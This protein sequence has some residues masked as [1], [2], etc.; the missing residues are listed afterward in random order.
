MSN[1]T[2]GVNNVKM[3]LPAYDGYEMYKIFIVTVKDSERLFCKLRQTFFSFL[4][5]IKVTF[6]QLAVAFTQSIRI[7]I[8]EHNYLTI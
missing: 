8:S 5:S 1:S 2:S 3:K 4:E 7:S 6:G